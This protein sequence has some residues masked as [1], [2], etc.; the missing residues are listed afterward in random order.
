MAPREPDRPVRA[1]LFDLDGTLIDSYALIASSFRHAARTVLARD[2][3]DDEVT[4][5][6]GE[7]LPARFAHLAPARVPALVAAYTDYY[8]AHHDRLC[9]LFPGV[10]EMLAGL[11]GRAPI[12]VVT[13][14][15][16]RSTALALRAFELERW[17]RV[18]V[19]AEDT[20][21]PK[22]APDPIVEAARRLGTPPRDAL[23]VGDGVFDIQAAR[24]AGARSAAAMWG[25]REGPAL[26]AAG[27][28]YVVATPARVVPLVGAG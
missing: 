2:L 9:V 3:A 20:P 14:K 22:P 19:S 26:L 7:P 15:R 6:W 18:A 11:D 4:A 12:G 28:D 27:P 13:S 16:R 24:A 25:T 23:V 5:H 1:V 21:A 8:D 17:V 10:V